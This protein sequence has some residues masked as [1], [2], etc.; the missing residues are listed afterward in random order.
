MDTVTVGKGS[1]MQ[2]MMENQRMC[3]IWRILLKNRAV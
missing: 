1:N 2:K 3:R